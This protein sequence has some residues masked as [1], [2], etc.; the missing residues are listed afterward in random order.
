MSEP[1]PPVDTQVQSGTAM[2]S[3]RL[4]QDAAIVVGAI[5]LLVISLLPVFLTPLLSR[6]MQNALGVSASSAGLLVAALQGGLAVGALGTAALLGRLGRLPMAIA[7]VTLA[8]IGWALT[9][10]MLAVGGVAAGVVGVML[11]IAGLGSGMAS[12]TGNS[13]L[14][15]ARAS[16]RAFSVA[17]FT[18]V[19]I[20]SLIIALMPTLQDLAADAGLAG[21]VSVIVA[22]C[23]VV[24]L[25]PTRT[26]HAVARAKF[27]S[28]ASIAVEGSGSGG[29][30][31]QTAS[32]PGRISPVAW[33]TVAAML[34]LS[35][36]NF[37]MWTYA[38]NV[39]EAAN[40]TS[41]TV[42]TALGVTQIIGLLGAAFV[43]VT[44]GQVRHHNILPV[45]IV[46]V[47][48]GNLLMGVTGVGNLY[49]VGLTIVNLGY[50]A[51]SPL[52]FA[53]GALLDR[54]GRVPAVLGATSM[55]GGFLAPIVAGVLIGPQ[56]SWA[57]LAWGSAVIVLLALPCALL[58]LR[59]AHQSALEPA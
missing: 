4:R 55:V 17:T 40:L 14:S 7:G 50:Y 22:L 16:V 35:V 56:E 44:N 30:G 57:T 33:I 6:D 20:G 11:A 25:V 34:A 8:V 31:A 59:A 47:A 9:S 51:F 18:T 52:I 42:T 36:G 2:A 1:S 53:Q 58:A 23:G 38:Q 26:R 43:A 3:P 15:Q 54:S 32:K 19:V 12:A 28:D 49:L 27:V 21:V 5:A 24:A 10:V 45:V 46:I 48:V 29:N 37:A 41:S 13:T 39:G